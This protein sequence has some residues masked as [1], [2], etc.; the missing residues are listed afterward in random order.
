MEWY[1]EKENMAIYFEES[2]KIS[3][4]YHSVIENYKQLKF[5][6]ILH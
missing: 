4:Q 3:C 5:L 1:Y 6:S 2:G